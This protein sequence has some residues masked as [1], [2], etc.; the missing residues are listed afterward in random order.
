MKINFDEIKNEY[1]Q[2]KVLE[3]PKGAIATG[4]KE[5]FNKDIFSK[6]TD[7]IKKETEGQTAAQTV[8]SVGKSLLKSTLGGLASY[9]NTVLEMVYGKE[10]VQEQMEL[11]KDAS[12][13]VTGNTDQSLQQISREISESLKQNPNATPF[14]KKYIGPAVALLIPTIDILTSG[15]GKTVS[16]EVY[17]NVIKKG[18]LAEEAEVAT[19]N[20]LIKKGVEKELAEEMIPVILKST[21][22]V[23]VDDSMKFVA[24]NRMRKIA[25]SESEEALNTVI[26]PVEIVDE[27]TPAETSIKESSL[28]KNIVEQSRMEGIDL[29]DVN[30]QT[31]EQRNILTQDLPK[32]LDFVDN[33]TALAKKIIAN[34]AEVPVE[35]GLYKESVYTA[36][37]Q[38]AIRERDVDTLMLLKNSDINLEATTLGQRIKALD[39]GLREADPV[40][41]A[42]EV[43]SANIEN[44]KKYNPKIEGDLIKTKESF[45][46]KSKEIKENIKKNIE[47]KETLE[48][49]IN[50]I[51]C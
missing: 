48:S 29:P 19:R 9:G 36:L 38:K 12:E 42:K 47:K 35:L 1:E 40:R 51:K 39:D 22:E 18:L 6:A 31:Y 21:T 30:V 32:A 5:T 14:E 28:S 17:K 11:K 37:K 16:Q 26:K 3:K 15:R 50:S 49:F 7:Y 24:V 33:N 45:K 34:E 23:E 44:A 8:F 2:T 20:I 10:K 13:F 27:I 43:E 41:I 4:I 25:E 46:R